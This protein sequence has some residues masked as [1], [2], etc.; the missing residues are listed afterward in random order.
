MKEDKMK[1]IQPK[2]GFDFT[3][4]MEDFSSS[5]LQSLSG[6]DGFIL[7]GRSP[8]SA[9]RDAKIHSGPNHG[10]ALRGKG[11]G[12]FG[13]AV[14]ERFSHLAIED[15]GRLRN[16]NPTIFFLSLL[17]IIKEDISIM[18]RT[19]RGDLSVFQMF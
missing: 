17:K 10:A 1:L 15:E 5:F 3:Q 8:T 11:P 13:K 7:K 12:F 4:K 2:T 9:I 19:H 6:V 18:Q 16:P 14:L